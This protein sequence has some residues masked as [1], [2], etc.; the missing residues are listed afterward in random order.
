M[1]AD[2]ERKRIEKAN[3]AKMVEMRQRQ[4]TAREEREVVA[5]YQALMEQEQREVQEAEEAALQA[6][7][8][9]VSGTCSR[10]V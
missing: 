5:K 6:L 10:A 7:M 2:V 4:K 1:A 3:A 8:N 9:Q